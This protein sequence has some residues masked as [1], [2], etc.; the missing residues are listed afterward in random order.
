MGP[1][2]EVLFGPASSRISD[3]LPVA[4]GFAGPTD[5]A[6]MAAPVAIVFSASIVTTVAITLVAAISES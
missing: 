5:W 3:Q 6:D 1:P 2:R 4:V